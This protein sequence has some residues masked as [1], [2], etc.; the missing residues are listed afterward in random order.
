M[1]INLNEH[2]HVIDD[3]WQEESLL[4]VLR[5]HLGLTGTK[6]G[7]GLGICGACTV[8]VNGQPI[9]SCLVPISSVV[10]A[11]ITTI[12]G[13]AKD[14]QLHPVQEAWLDYSVPQ[15][16]YCQAGQIMTAVAFLETNSQPTADQVT[17][18]MDNNLCRCG[19]YK[20]VKQ[21][22]LAAA[23]SI[24]SRKTIESE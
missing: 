14:G 17:A 15:C 8:H 12:E 7:C 5:D 9:R 3:D 19:T 11:S 23:K 4:S 6:F 1:Q 21:A 13:L 24:E 18:A 2:L 16:G 20:R 10:D 22:V